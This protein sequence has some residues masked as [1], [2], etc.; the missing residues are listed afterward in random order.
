MQPVNPPQRMDNKKKTQLQHTNKQHI[1]K[2]TI[3]TVQC[4]QSKHFRCVQVGQNGQIGQN[5]KKQNKFGSK[6]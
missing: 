1:N 2:F 6:I 3:A 5:S 4:R